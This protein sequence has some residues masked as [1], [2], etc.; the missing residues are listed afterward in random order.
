MKGDKDFYY[1]PIRYSWISFAPSHHTAVISIVPHQTCQ[2][3]PPTP[4]F[5]IY[6]QILHI[7]SHPNDQIPKC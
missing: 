3:P 7:Y 1:T 5:E 4:N 6:M 2:Q